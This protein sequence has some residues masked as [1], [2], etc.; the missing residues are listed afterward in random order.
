MEYIFGRETFNAFLDKIIIAGES[1][2]LSPLQSLTLFGILTL[3]ILAV[4]AIMYR[5]IIS[6]YKVKEIKLP[7]DATVKSEDDSKETVFNKNMDEIIYFFEETN[8][9]LVF[10]EDLDRLENSSIFVHLRELN[11]LLNNYEAI[12][13]PIIFVY[14]VKDNIFF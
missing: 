10:F 4:M 2:K 8:Y 3:G 9:R 13:E 11:T 5:S 7:V 1:V 14:A 12:K 6:H